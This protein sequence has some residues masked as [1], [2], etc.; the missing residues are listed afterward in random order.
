MVASDL[1]VIRIIAGNSSEVV[2][3]ATGHR[4][5][6]L[7]TNAGR[8]TEIQAAIP[9]W[10]AKDFIA[11]PADA[12]NI[13]FSISRPVTEQPVAPDTEPRGVVAPHQRAGAFDRLTSGVLDRE[14]LCFHE[15]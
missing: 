12:R 5:R 2:P 6:Q 3:V 13:A 7:L 11:K 8:W 10:C 14:W 9:I 4:L 1:K 15:R